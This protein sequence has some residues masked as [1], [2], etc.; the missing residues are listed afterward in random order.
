M[1]APVWTGGPAQASAAHPPLV[2]EQVGDDL[3]HAGFGVTQVCYFLSYVTS[4]KLLCLSEPSS[5]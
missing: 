5:C 1:L 2:I 3:E 4:G